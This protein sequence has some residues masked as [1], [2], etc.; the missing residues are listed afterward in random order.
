MAVFFKHKTGEGRAR[1][2]RYAGAAAVCL[3]VVSVILLPSCTLISRLGRGSGSGTEE[4]T[5][6]GWTPPVL[7]DEG[8]AAGTADPVPEERIK[9]FLPEK[10]PDDVYSPVRVHYD[11]LDPEEQI[12][13]LESA[14]LK[15]LRNESSAVLFGK[16]ALVELS[17]YQ[18]SVSVT[19]FVSSEGG[20]VSCADAVRIINR[21]REKMAAASKENRAYFEPFEPVEFASDV[22][23]PDFLDTDGV[24]VFICP[25]KYSE[26]K[27]IG[28]CV[29]IVGADG[30]AVPY[31]GDLLLNDAARKYYSY[32]FYDMDGDGGR[33][34]FV[35]GPGGTSGLRS[36]S[37]F[38]YRLGKTPSVI[39]GTPTYPVFSTV[40]LKLRAATDG[41]PV[42][43][44]SCPD[45]DGAERRSLY[46]AELAPALSG[47]KDGL[48]IAFRNEN[49]EPASLDVCSLRLSAQVLSGGS[50]PGGWE[51]DT[52]DRY[53]EEKVFEGYRNFVHDS[54]IDRLTFSRLA[55]FPTA[56]GYLFL[57]AEGSDLFRLD[58]DGKASKERAGA[59]TLNL[60]TACLSGPMSHFR[61]VYPVGELY[62]EDGDIYKWDLYS[63]TVSTFID[64]KDRLDRTCFRE[65]IIFYV[66]YDGKKAVLKAAPANHSADA[67]VFR[68]AEIPTPDPARIVGVSTSG[69]YISVD[70][71]GVYFVRFAGGGTTKICGAPEGGFDY[72][73]TADGKLYAAGDG[74]LRAYDVK[75]KE[76]W[77]AAAGGCFEVYGDDLITLSA[78]GIEFIHP[79]SAEPYRRVELRIGSLA[80]ANKFNKPWAISNGKLYICLQGGTGDLAAV[81]LNS[82][83]KTV[84]V[85]EGFFRQ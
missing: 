49:G 2:N 70:R 60:Y 82:P 9:S 33:D 8:S 35:H 42:V 18:R 23:P 11:D 62:T 36:E 6:D 69:A 72:L 57:R 71:D 21:D 24:R 55:V 66:T 50:Y 73:K 25:V 10:E 77:S 43:V 56:R 29:F 64:V 40:G 81:D 78:D 53:V 3:A 20:A 58:K 48:M 12:K 14:G 83:E 54:N 5:T 31:A 37:F 38:V 39:A 65:G 79:G 47:E 67:P 26:S 30:A 45:E 1:K 44:A 4:G 75:G 16:G 85:T 28:T 32:V 17:W 63:A 51:K 84:T 13:K 61:Y 68:I 15:C 7:P 46:T 80:A 27:K 22:T 34:L 76:L 41:R 52:D 74:T 19:V 59:Y